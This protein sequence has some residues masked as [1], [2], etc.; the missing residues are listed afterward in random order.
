[1]DE[2][3]RAVRRTGLG[4]MLLF[5]LL[6]L[7][8]GAWWFHGYLEQRRNPNAHLVHAVAGEGGDVVLQR[9]VSG[10]FV[11]TGRINGEPVEFLLDTGATYLA[12]SADLAARLGL[13][14]G[15]PAFFHTANGR[16]QGYLTEIDQVSLG[17][18]ATHN[19][20]GS[21]NPGMS[22]DAALLGMSFL[23]RFDIE[24]RGNEMVLRAP[25]R[26]VQ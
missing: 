8:I 21:I 4:M 23:N 18:L 16:V 3:E 9:N 7:A 20:R 11:A 22:G 17:G 25:Q 1:M 10:H 15:R 19:V 13:E 12:V 14:R 26:P 24:I 5:W 2:D 6:V